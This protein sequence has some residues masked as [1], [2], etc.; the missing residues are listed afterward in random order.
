MERRKLE[1]EVEEDKIEC[2]TN[3][4]KRLK[5]TDRHISRETET[6]RGTGQ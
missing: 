6:D 5:E 2:Q 1:E 3:R 4:K